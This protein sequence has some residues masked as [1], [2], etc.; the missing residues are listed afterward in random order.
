VSWTGGTAHF[1]IAPPRTRRRMISDLVYSRLQ[2][3]ARLRGALGTEKHHYGLTQCS[4]DFTT[5]VLFQCI[6]CAAFFV[7]CRFKESPRYFS[8]RY[9]II[10]KEDSLLVL[11][12][13][14]CSPLCVRRM[15]RGVD[16]VIGR[17]QTE[18][19]KRLVSFLAHFQHTYIHRKLYTDK[20]RKY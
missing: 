14:L 9:R 12:L 3:P 18:R 20:T 6:F 8:V 2:F 5:H 1:A 13:R 7:S 11:L 19:T 16:K 10:S 4:G 15:G 17:D